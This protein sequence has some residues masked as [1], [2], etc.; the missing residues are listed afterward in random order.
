MTPEDVK[1]QLADFKKQYRDLY[2]NDE[3]IFRIGPDVYEV[4]Q[5]GA[6]RRALKWQFNEFHDGANY[7]V[8]EYRF[9]F[10]IIK[11]GAVKAGYE[12]RSPVAG[13][14]Q[15]VPWS[16]PLGEFKNIKSLEEIDALFRFTSP[17]YK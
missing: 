9:W 6:Q 16:Y 3:S 11:D 8:G 5:V 1:N 2:E 15:S 12:H 17:H 7:M 4:V 14:N 10:K 13:T